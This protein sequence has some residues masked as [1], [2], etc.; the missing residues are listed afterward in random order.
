[1][2][3]RGLAVRAIF[4][5]GL[6]LG[7]A[8]AQTT[9]TPATGKFPALSVQVSVGTQQ[10]PEARSSYRK[11]MTIAPKLVIQGVARLTPIPAAEAEMMIITMDTRAKYKAK[12]EVY[13]VHET[14]TMPIPA[15]ANGERRQFSF[16]ESSVTYDSY[17]DNSNVGGEIYKYYVFALR[18]PETKAVLDFKTNHPGL[19]ALVKS[20]PAK[21]DEV[22]GL[23]KGKPF[24]SDF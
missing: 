10:R 13:Q 18:D 19:A 4:L 8:H 22:L 6:L 21:R 16:T 17:R 24:P 20:Q 11:T 2:I 1:M 5:L 9:A 15:A 7:S 23:A 12:I 14:E 3:T